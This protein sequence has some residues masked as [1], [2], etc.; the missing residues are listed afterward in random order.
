MVDDRLV[1]DRLVDEKA[2]PVCRHL[3]TKMFYI[4][5][6]LGLRYMEQTMPTESYWCM[7]TMTAT[8]P[9]DQPVEPDECGRD[10]RCREER[11]ESLAF[12]VGAE[13]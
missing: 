12:D 10:R 2:V 11:M 9:D 1:D 3:R 13:E 8:G 6:A 7:K 5:E 4:S